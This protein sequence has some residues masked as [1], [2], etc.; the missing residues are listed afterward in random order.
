MPGQIDDELDIWDLF[1]T[2]YMWIKHFVSE[3]REEATE[4]KLLEK[5]DDDDDDSW[6]ERMANF[7]S[8]ES[9]ELVEDVKDSIEHLE[10]F[11]KELPTKLQDRNRDDH[12][13][14]KFLLKR[15]RRWLI[16]EFNEL[17]DENDKIR[18]L[19]IS[20]DLG[21][22]I[23]IGLI[24]DD[25]FEHGFDVINNYDYKQWL[26]KHGANKK[27]TVNSAPV[28][29]FYDLVFAYEQGNYDKPNIE[30]GTIIRCM[31]RIALNYKGAIMWKMQAGMGDT[32]FTPFYQA[33][34]DRGV[35]FEY[36]NK[37]EEITAD[38]NT[39]NSIRITEQVKLK[40]G[41][42]SYNPLVNVPV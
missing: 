37:V 30:A 15:L 17:L 40:D 2:A 24:E 42:T 3:L 11:L 13:A 28:R 35:K 7:I 1:R 22:T 12:N 39:V 26:R 20:A 10:N 4:H 32:I 21:L 19:F 36:F 34:Q 23:L 25:V 29:G 8:V 38:S 5:D 6:L 41:V 33:L 9:Q 14:I 16:S 31:M 18:R 27:Y